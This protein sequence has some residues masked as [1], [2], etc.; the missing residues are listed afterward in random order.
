MGQTVDLIQHHL[1]QKLHPDIVGLRAFPQAGV[2]VLAAKKLDVVVALVEVEV[3]VSS[4][5]R[6]FQNAGE[7]AGLLGDGGPLA[8]RPLLHLLYLFPGG[9]VNDGLMDIEEDCP[10]FLRVLN[11]LFHFVGLGVG[12]EI[13]HIAAILLGG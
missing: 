7:Y 1:F 3:E 10:V 9:P 2:M 12:F 13:D 6:A 11:A 4:A 8:A 5:L